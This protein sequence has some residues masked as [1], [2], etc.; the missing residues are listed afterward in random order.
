MGNF[1]MLCGAVLILLAWLSPISAGW[2]WLGAILLL[3]GWLI[4]R[5]NRHSATGDLIEGAVDLLDADIDI[6]D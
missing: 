6:L 2:G 4:R 5:S 3:V 1:L